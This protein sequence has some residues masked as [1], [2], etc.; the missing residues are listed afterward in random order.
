M[1]SAPG[2]SLL[3]CSAHLCFHLWA[4]VSQ[5][6]HGF[7]GS[8]HLQL[9]DYWTQGWCA[10]AVHLFSRHGQTWFFALLGFVALIFVPFFS[11]CFLL[12]VAIS[13]PLCND[14]F[15]GLPCNSICWSLPWETH[16]LSTPV[17][18]R[19]TQHRKVTVTQSMAL[20]IKSGFT[21]QEM[22]IKLED[23][24]KFEKILKLCIIHWAIL[25]VSKDQSR[26]QKVWYQLKSQFSLV[27][28]LK[29][30]NWD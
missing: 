19:C 11:S 8:V 23:G 21:Q 5:S 6:P 3:G 17:Q 2:R 9:V 29:N 16:Y 28:H 13:T 12:V 10:C 20:V 18:R 22:R 24:W 1:C 25:R 26:C 7:P 14:A 15:S 30:L 4:L 27:L